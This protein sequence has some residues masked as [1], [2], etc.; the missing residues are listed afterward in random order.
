MNRV[1][2]KIADADEWRAARVAGIYYG[3]A[4]DKRDG[5]IH[6]STATQLPGTLAKHFAGREGLV[7]IAVDAGRIG[8]KLSWEPARDGEL[9]PHLYHPLPTDAAVWFTPL[10]LK[11]DRTH[12]VPADLPS[13]LPGEAS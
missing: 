11:A 12:D 7:L 4:D 13:A 9:F 5:Y 3:S 6:F 2:Y 10:T 8:D 1:I